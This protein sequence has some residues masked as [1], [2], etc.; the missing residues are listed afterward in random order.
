[1][2]RDHYGDV[3]GRLRQNN[4]WAHLSRFNTAS[5]E[6]LLNRGAYF[7]LGDLFPAGGC[8]PGRAAVL[9][10][11]MYASSDVRRCYYVTRQLAL[12]A[13]LLA[14]D[15]VAGYVRCATIYFIIKWCRIMRS[16]SQAL[17][18]NK[19]LFPRQLSLISIQQVNGS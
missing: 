12:C 5:V 14:D 9:L 4:G 2:F 13:R 18:E 11:H 17:S 15:V 1:M 16:D 7:Q 3:F 19:T 6:R 8:F 10:T